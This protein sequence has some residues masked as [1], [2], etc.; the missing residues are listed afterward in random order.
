MPINGVCYWFGLLED[1]GR[2][3]SSP[4]PRKRTL[5]ALQFQ[6]ERLHPG[7]GPGYHKHTALIAAAGT[8]TSISNINL[9]S[10]G[11]CCSIGLN[12][13]RMTDT[14]VG[15]KI[16]QVQAIEPRQWFDKNV[17]FL[18]P[19][20]PPI[21]LESRQDNMSKHTSLLKDQ[22]SASNTNSCF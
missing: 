4:D 12:N 1:Q 10:F 17:L 19:V 16:H 14:N 3:L 2:C 7:K 22:W 15:P 5:T 6:Q 21:S 13:Q 18:V 20:G 11:S 9:K 8:E